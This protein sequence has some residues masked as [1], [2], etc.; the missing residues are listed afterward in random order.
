LF[1][2]TSIGCGVNRVA[3]SNPSTL[4][5]A[6]ASSAKHPMMPH[7]GFVISDAFSMPVPSRAMDFRLRQAL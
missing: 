7:C 5:T 3:A 2:A 6:Q 1:A 4:N